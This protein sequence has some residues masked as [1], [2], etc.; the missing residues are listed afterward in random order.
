MPTAGFGPEYMPALIANVS[1]VLTIERMLRCAP[2]LPDFVARRFMTFLLAMPD[3]GLSP[4][5]SRNSS[6]MSRYLA[7]VTGFNARNAGD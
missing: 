3:I 5:R 2:L 4:F 6:S 1:S 7:L